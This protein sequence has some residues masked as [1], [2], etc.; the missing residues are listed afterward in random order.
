MDIKTQYD[1]IGEEYVS[2]QKDFFSK[3]DDEAFQFI[4]GSLPDIHGKAVL[5]IGC[6]HG[7]D[8]KLLESLGANVYGID[9]SAFMIDKAKKVVSC[10]ENL[11]VG[12]I[13]HTEFADQ[14]FDVAVGRF[15]LHYLWNFEY[16]YPEIA[17]ILKHH[18]ILVLVVHHPFRDLTYK[19]NKVY[20]KQEI[21]RIKLYDNKV[22][23]LFPTHT[24]KDYFSKKFF[25]SF[26]L[27][28]Y[29]E[30]H[31]PEEGVDEFQTPAFMGFSAIRKGL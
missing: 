5:D 26:Y 8:I 14:T 18:G 19:K 25:E 20:S 3:R 29:E 4:K 24:L 10:P 13:E 9:T 16:A 22:P 28:G 1:H 21:V 17:R 12:N 23:I 7:Q 15:S 2:G 31:S 27:T 30:E 11:V 6:G